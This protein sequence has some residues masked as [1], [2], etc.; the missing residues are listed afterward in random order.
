MGG[1]LGPRTSVDALQKIYLELPEIKSVFFY[2]PGSR[3]VS[4]SIEVSL[5]STKASLSD[6]IV[7]Q[8]F[9]RDKEFKDDYLQQYKHHPEKCKG[10]VKHKL[11]PVLVML[12][13]NCFHQQTLLLGYK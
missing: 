9:G 11:N 13:R 12:L 3:L 2:C 1:C 8:K 4:M 7:Y 5:L 10:T 6:N